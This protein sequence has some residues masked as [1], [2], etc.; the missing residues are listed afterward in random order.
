MANERT[1]SPATGK[2]AHRRRTGRTAHPF[3]SLSG[4]TAV[5]GDELEDVPDGGIPLFGAALGCFAA[6]SIA[7]A[8]L[9]C[10]PETLVCPLLTR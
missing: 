5:L 6:N 9:P 1:S 3:F 4:D 10:A 2:I 8:R 7:A